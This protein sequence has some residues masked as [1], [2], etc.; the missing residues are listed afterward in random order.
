MKSPVLFIVF[1]RLQVVKEVFNQIKVYQP[2]KLYISSDGARPEH[3][4]EVKKVQEVRNYILNQ[5]DW[6]CQVETLFREENLGCK[7][8][9]Q[10]AISWF[11]ENEEHGIILEDDCLPSESF[12]LY[13]EKL[14]KKYENDFRIYGITGSNF[15]SHIPVVESYYFS[16][17]FFTWGWASWKSRWEKHLQI[18]KSF[19]ANIEDEGN[20][21]LIQNKYAKNHLI[22]KATAAYEDD[23][24]A[25]DYLWILS[26][27]INNGHIVTPEKNLIKNIGF[28]ADAT[29]T[30]GNLRNQRALENIRF[31]LEHPVQIISNKKLDNL[32]FKNVKQ[33]MGPYDKITNL[34]Y[35]R[36]YKKVIQ[37]RFKTAINIT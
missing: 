10:K 15:N 26:C 18:Q 12:F 6:P 29:H 8:A 32:L 11:F 19:Y 24:D 25:W 22:K 20:L 17:Y 4:G 13:C 9:P 35:L 34:G 21:K 30:V 1:N 5:I 27:V 2:D 33:W 36:E 31:P 3:F 14:L 28:G 23:I 16:S 37:N 7:Y